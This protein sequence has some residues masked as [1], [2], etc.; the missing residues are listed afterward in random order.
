MKKQT[1]FTISVAN[2]RCAFQTCQTNRLIYTFV[3][4]MDIKLLFVC[5][6]FLLFYHGNQLRSCLDGQL[7]LPGF[8]PQLLVGWLVGWLILNVPVNFFQSCWDGASASWVFPVLWGSK[9]ALLKDTTR[10]DPSGART[11]DLWIRS[12]RH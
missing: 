6:D 9:C 7:S 8:S 3:I 5:F 11:P 10:F 4:S 12:P 2:S 1:D